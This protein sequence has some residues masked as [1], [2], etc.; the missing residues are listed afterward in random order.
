VLVDWDSNSTTVYTVTL[1][2]WAAYQKMSML[3][4]ADE[5][6]RAGLAAFQR[7]EMLMGSTEK[8]RG[9]VSFQS[10]V[11]FGQ[12]PNLSRRSVA[13]PENSFTYPYRESVDKKIRVTVRY[14]D[15]STIEVTVYP[16]MTTSS[17]KKLCC[18]GFYSHYFSRTACK[19]IHC[20]SEAPMANV[21]KEQIEIS[22]NGRILNDSWTLGGKY[23][24]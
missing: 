17:M 15:G 20:I 9:D 4:E 14:W 12:S 16:N 21:L 22:S 13:A 5:A 7:V 10:D 2:E 18:R 3:N 1:R 24:T 8:S 23:L 6:E 19:Y 11:M